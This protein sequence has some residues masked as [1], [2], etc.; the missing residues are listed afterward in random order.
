[1]IT[2]DGSKTLFRLFHTEMQK[3]H[4]DRTIRQRDLADFLDTH[5]SCVSTWKKGDRLL[6]SIEDYYNLV[7][8][9]GNYTVDELYQ[10]ATGEKPYL[11]TRTIKQIR[12]EQK[13]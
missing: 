10:V 11:E 7:K 1:M 5:E 3:K 6:N 12:K 13:L 8:L 4:K 2:K 9:L